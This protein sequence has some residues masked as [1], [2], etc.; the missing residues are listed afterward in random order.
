MLTFI[1]CAKTMAN[2]FIEVQTPV[3]S[4]PHFQ[5]EALHNALDMSQYSPAELE[6]LLRVNS[7]IAT[8]N[9]LRYQDFCSPANKTMPAIFAYTGAVYKRISSKDFSIDDFFY[10]QDHLRITSFLYGLLR[11]LDAIKPYRLEGDVRLPERGGRT[12]FEYWK[13]LLTDW[14]IES[15][16]EKGGILLNL[17]SAEMQNLFDWNRVQ[18][19]VRVVTPDFHVWKAGRLATIVIYVKMCRGEMARLA[20]KDRI[21]DPEQLQSFSWEGF[22]Y[23]ENRSTENHYVYTFG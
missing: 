8:D 3:V 4:L 12:M 9:Y 15:I 17:A 18:H 21:A 1:S 20:M 5:E 22:K 6:R 2:N 11:P 19:E 13:P 16:K 10:V 23:D 7:K 14:F